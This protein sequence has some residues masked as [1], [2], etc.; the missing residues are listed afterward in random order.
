MGADAAVNGTDNIFYSDL[1][2]TKHSTE[3][4]KRY[5]SENNV[6]LEKAQN[7][8][9]RWNKTAKILTQTWMNMIGRLMCVEAECTMW[10]HHGI[11]RE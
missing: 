6:S 11:S 1:Q 8:L 7:W 10:E 9:S 2:H 4:Y 5:W 3:C